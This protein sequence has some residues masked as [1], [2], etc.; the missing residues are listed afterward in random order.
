MNTCANCIYEIAGECHAGPMTV[1]SITDRDG[2][3]VAAS[4]WPEAKLSAWC[5]KWKALPVSLA[6][7]TGPSEPGPMS[8]F[9][10][11]VNIAKGW[12]GA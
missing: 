5:G 7:M 1:V 6:A 11:G 8:W 10:K 4:Y 12:R 3:L 9:R 2:D